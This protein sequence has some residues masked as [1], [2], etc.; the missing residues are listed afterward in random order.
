MS[1]EPD[2]QAQE[3]DVAGRVVPLVVNVA[4]RMCPCGTRNAPTQVDGPHV[5]SV[6]ED[7]VGHR[8][9][10]RDALGVQ[11]E[12]HRDALRQPVLLDVAAQMSRH[13][14]E[15]AACDLGGKAA[16]HVNRDG[17]LVRLVHGP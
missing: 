5:A 4:L 7:R 17:G 1:L 9:S 6:D 15:H 11:L 13:G 2:A 3:L 8:M 16:L 12:R 10:V 14:L